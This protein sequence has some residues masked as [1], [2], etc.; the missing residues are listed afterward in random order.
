MWVRR[1]G[2]VA[3]PLVLALYL[4]S[5]VAE[6]P[7]RVPR[8]VLVAG[9]LV[10]IGQGLALYWRR[11]HPRLV[12]AI[13]LAGGLVVQVIAPYGLIP[14]A[15]MVALWTLA[16]AQPPAISL[17]ALAALLGV[18]AAAAARGAQAGDV[19][20]VMVLVVV[21]W[22]LGEATRNRLAASERAAAQAVAEE[23]ARLARELHDV[24][25]HSVSVMVLQAAAAD[26]VFDARPDRARTALQEIESVGRQ[27]MSELRWLLAA[28]GPGEG[29]ARQPSPDL[30]R[31]DELAGTVRAAAGLRVDVQ[32]HGDCAAI[33]AGVSLSAYRIVQEA[34]TNT[35][36]HAHAS[37]VQIKISAE[38][39]ALEV[40][41]LDDGRGGTYTEGRGLIGMRERAVL[42]GGTLRVGPREGGGF[43][44]WA[45][46]PLRDSET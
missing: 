44:V 30:S 31:L 5:L 13:A 36:R 8:L 20:F 19:G 21:V 14:L 4:A 29:A 40:A 1:A 26:D 11:A 18:T 33:P 25:A 15:G 46:I 3:G 34:L 27:A 12:M 23:Q 28:T 45:R 2:E 6:T 32:R 10:G 41:V 17:P 43:G 7:E 35:V 42:L 16:A 24:L 9:V 39:N 38:P 37:A 22:A